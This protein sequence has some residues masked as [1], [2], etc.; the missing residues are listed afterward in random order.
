MHAGGDHLEGQLNGDHEVFPFRVVEGLRLAGVR[1]SAEV[2]AVLAPPTEFEMRASGGFDGR[3]ACPVGITEVEI[4]ARDGRM[5][6]AKGTVAKLRCGIY[7]YLIAVF[8]VCSVCDSEAR[9]V[10]LFLPE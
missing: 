5:L 3:V 9:A 7:S 4:L 1:T 8:V 2:A 10:L 6:R